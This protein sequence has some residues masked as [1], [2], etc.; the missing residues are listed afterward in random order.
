MTAKAILKRLRSLRAGI[1][2]V[3]GRIRVSAPTG[4]LTPELKAA[5]A[6]KYVRSVIGL[7]TTR[8]CIAYET[9]IS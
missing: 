4:V 1:S 7:I 6:A 5:L 3:E 9:A 8:R 2:V